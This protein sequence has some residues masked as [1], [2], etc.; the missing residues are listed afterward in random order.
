MKTFVIGDVHG[1]RQQLRAILDHIPRDANVDSLVLLG[2]LIDRGEDAPGVIEEVIAA[3][4][5]DDGGGRV[6][7]LR[8]NHEQMF[9]DFLEEKSD[10]WLTHITGCERT[11]EQYTG[12]SLLVETE[13]PLPIEQAREKLLRSVPAGH[14]ALLR[15]TPL[16]HEDEYAI[17]VHAGL[18]RDLKHPRE[19]AP[20]LLLWSRA[21]EF[22]KSYTGKL[23]VFGHTPT[24]FLPLLGRLGHHGVYMAHSAIG[25]DTSGPSG[26]PLS[27]LSLPDFT[28]YQSFPNGQTSVRHLTAFLPE[29]MRALRRSAEIN[30]PRL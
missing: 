21:A 28:L 5:E 2:D 8:G 15:A 3:R 23:C 16:Y 30:R 10:F 18:S 9:L 11:F 13:D 26:A 24:V 27:C 25:L 22:F 17:Y 6:V 1:R 4:R 29:P 7:L 12:E 20:E 14:L 19:T